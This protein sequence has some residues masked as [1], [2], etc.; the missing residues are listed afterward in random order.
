M[1]IEGLLHC[2][3]HHHRGPMGLIGGQ[4]SLGFLEKEMGLLGNL[5]G[6]FGFETGDITE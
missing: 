4:K 3:D 5:G 6:I 2:L 1:L